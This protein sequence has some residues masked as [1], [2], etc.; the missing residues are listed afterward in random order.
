LLGLLQKVD[1]SFRLARQ[2]SFRAVNAK[3]FMVDL[4]RAPFSEPARAT[5][6]GRG[7]DLIA[8]PL[9]GL[10]WLAD[11]PRMT[12]IVIAENGYPLR[13][14]VPD[15]RV[16]ALH[17]IWLS[18]QPTRDPMKRKRDF[19]QGE[20]VARLALDYLNLSFDDGA[21]TELPAALTSMKAGLIERL[22][23]RRASADQQPEISL[24]PGFDDID[25]EPA[26]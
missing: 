11:A 7:E 3:G 16:F 8:E 9:H 22:Q 21:I 18:L 5:T 4:I 2:R 6:I 23:S 17:K 13:F 1:K 12:Q 15:P 25:D 19:R 24:P 14:M 20:A 26:V 10:E